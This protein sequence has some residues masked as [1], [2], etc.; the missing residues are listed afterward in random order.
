M[1]LAKSSISI[2]ANWVIK[3][4]KNGNRAKRKCD[5]SFFTFLI[6]DLKI[7]LND[8]ELNSAPGNQ[9]YFSKKSECGT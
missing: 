7:V 8:A 4:A 3:I 1:E 9:T 2:N 6:L 5:T